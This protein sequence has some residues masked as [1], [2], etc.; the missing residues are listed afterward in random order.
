MKRLIFAAIIVIASMS[1]QAE[2]VLGHYITK[3]YCSIEFTDTPKKAE[4]NT[5]YVAK[6]TCNGQVYRFFY[7]YNEKTNDAW[8]YTNGWRNE[9]FVINL[10]QVT[11]GPIPRYDPEVM[12]DILQAELIGQSVARN[13]RKNSW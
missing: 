12:R 1:A 8:L 9:P 4:G 10:S 7:L 11:Q 6:K 2:Q 3:D 5:F 13:L